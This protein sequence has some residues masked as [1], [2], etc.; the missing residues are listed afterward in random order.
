MDSDIK[1]VAWVDCEYFE[2][3]SENDEGSEPLYDQSAIDRLT[4][5]RDALRSQLDWTVREND[6]LLDE[7]RDL[8][9]KL[10][11]YK[12]DSERLRDILLDVTCVAICDLYESYKDDVESEFSLTELQFVVETSEPLQADGVTVESVYRRGFDA[13]RSESEAL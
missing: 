6:R 7:G 5:E 11:E 3:V 4:E 13:A 2:F 8:S 12:E 1:P 9:G 10:A